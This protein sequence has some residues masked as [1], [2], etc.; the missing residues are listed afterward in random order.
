MLAEIVH[1]EHVPEPAVMKPEHFVP[2][3]SFISKVWPSQPVALTLAETVQ[4]AVE[5][6]AETERVAVQ[7]NEGL[8]IPLKHVPPV[9]TVP[10]A[11]FAY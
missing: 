4:G 10:S 7:D 3:E 8:Q 6:V 5:G 1:E 9:H 11:F 2:A